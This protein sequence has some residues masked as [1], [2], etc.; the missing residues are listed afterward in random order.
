M[1]A[2]GDQT[3]KEVMKVQLGHQILVLDQYDG[4]LVRRGNVVTERH[5]GCSAQ[6]KDHVGTQKAVSQ[7]REAAGETKPGN[8][9]SLDVELPKL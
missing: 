9:W 7:G 3:S 8:T 4:V 1:T 2:S 6:R 5:H